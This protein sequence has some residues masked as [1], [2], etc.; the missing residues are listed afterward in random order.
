MFQKMHIQRTVILAFFALVLVLFSQF[1]SASSEYRL[2]IGD[3]IKI[4]VYEEP[5]LSFELTIDGAGSFSYPYLKKL[6]L[7]DKTIPEL[8]KEI[9][10]GL[11]SKVLVDPQVTILLV[12]YRP[13]SIG[14]EVVKPGSYPFKPGLTVLKAIN[15]AGGATEI[16]SVD[17]VRLDRAKALRDE[18]VTLNT[19]VSPGDTITVLKQLLVNIGGEVKSPGSYPLEPGLTVKRAINL[20]GGPSEWSTGRKFK[21]ERAIPID[22]EKISLNSIIQSGDTLTVLPRRFFW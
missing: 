1:A 9:T 21:L 19:R 20:A 6:K 3:K 18:V 16:G 5:D 12:E 17:R 10:T 4:Q 8:E 14:G 2:G 7:I 13:F 11:S 22:G 15:L